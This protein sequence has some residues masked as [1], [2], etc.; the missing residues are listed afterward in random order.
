V[1]IGGLGVLSFLSAVGV[2]LAIHGL[3]LWPAAGLPSRQYG[4]LWTAV[5]QAVLVAPVLE[6]LVLGLLY[7]MFATAFPVRLSACLAGLVVAAW[8]AV[9]G[10]PAAVCAVIPFQILA[11]PFAAPGLSLRR[12]AVH[13]MAMHAVHNACAVG[14]LAWAGG[15]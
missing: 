6:T 12:A 13:S 4:D 5:W 10:W 9:L 2:A 3:G 14:M 11:A 7:G 8:H 15:P 1:R